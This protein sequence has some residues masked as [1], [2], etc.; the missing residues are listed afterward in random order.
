MEI[1][2]PADDWEAQIGRQ[3]RGLRLRSD[4][5]QRTLAERAGVAL[6][7]V[8][9]LEAGKGSTLSSLIRVLRALGRVDWLNSLSPAVSISPMQILKSKPAR[10]RASRKH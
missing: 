5:D 2:V 7:V 6:N 10:R 3:L 4:L 1:H 9:N 8:K